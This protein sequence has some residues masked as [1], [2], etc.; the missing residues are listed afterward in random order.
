MGFSSKRM[1][2]FGHNRDHIMPQG[3][4]SSLVEKSDLI[5]YCSCWLYTC[6]TSF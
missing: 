5:T 3:I 1:D 6:V 2:I 4:R